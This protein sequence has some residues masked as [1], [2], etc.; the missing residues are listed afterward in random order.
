[1]STLEHH[2]RFLQVRHH[3]ADCGLPCHP[4]QVR[5]DDCEDI[6]IDDCLAALRE[7]L[8]ETEQ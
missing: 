5:C 7:A 6:V 8:E 2:V 3:C 1:M 4:D